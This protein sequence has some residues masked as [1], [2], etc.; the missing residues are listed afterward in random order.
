MERL[1]AGTVASRQ[2]VVLAAPG[3]PV[4]KPTILVAAD[5]EKAHVVLAGLSSID[6]LQDSFR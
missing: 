5:S 4:D 1:P 2:M 3:A 6:E